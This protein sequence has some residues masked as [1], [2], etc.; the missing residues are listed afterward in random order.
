LKAGFY[1]Y[2]VPAL[3]RNEGLNAIIP[4]IQ[5]VPSTNVFLTG[6]TNPSDAHFVLNLPSPLNFWI[7]LFHK[8]MMYIFPEKLGNTCWIPESSV[9]LMKA[10]RRVYI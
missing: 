8:S 4:G 9:G 10:A 2:T 6:R 7:F 5:Q 1:A 3:Q